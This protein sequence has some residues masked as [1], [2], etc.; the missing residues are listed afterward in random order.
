MERDSR[1]GR[2][3]HFLDLTRPCADGSNAAIVTTGASNAAVAALLL[4]RDKPFLPPL[5]H[6][7]TSHGDSPLSY[8]Y[9]PRQQTY[10]DVYAY[11][12]RHLKAQKRLG[13][14]SSKAKEVTT[15]QLLHIAPQLLL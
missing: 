6:L 8:G 15:G 7:E 2:S 10:Y 9:V 3:K 4:K 1:R 5:A 12:F 14:R 13:T 11:G